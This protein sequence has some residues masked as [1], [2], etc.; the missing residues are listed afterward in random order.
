MIS[1]RS[2]G[3][4][5]QL[6]LNGVAIGGGG[7][8]A[9]GL[10]LQNAAG[11]TAGEVLFGPGRLR[12]ADPQ[13][14]TFVGGAAHRMV[15]PIRRVAI[16]ASDPHAGVATL[17]LAAPRNGRLRVLR[18]ALSFPQATDSS[19]Q[20]RTVLRLARRRAGALAPAGTAVAL[21]Q[22]LATGE[23]LDLGFLPTREEADLS[24]GDE[25][26]LLVERAAAALQPI[27][28]LV[29]EIAHEAD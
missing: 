10:R 17:T 18:V 11:A 13:P 5:A 12:L 4:D 3:D 22:P 2:V 9:V 27:A 21:G 25:L 1:G 26:V 19:V 14:L 29:Y 20:T 16:L 28:A 24:P 6:V 8:A 23:E 15:R 7:P